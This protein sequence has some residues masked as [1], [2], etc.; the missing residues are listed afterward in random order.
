MEQADTLE[1]IA[2]QLAL[3]EA[4]SAAAKGEVPVGAVVLIDGVVVARRGN[5]REASADPTAHAEVL[6][7]RDAAR[8]KGSWRLDGATLVSTLEPCLMCT[9][10]A[11]AARVARIVFGALD[12]KGGGCGSLYNLA[13][14]PRLNHQIALS[15]GVLEDEAAQLLQAFF[16]NLRSSA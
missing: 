8:S 1:N 14:D 13:V 11:V 9:A 7:L 6:A 2:M 15:N 4:A 16:T 3:E 10:A 12:P 5:E